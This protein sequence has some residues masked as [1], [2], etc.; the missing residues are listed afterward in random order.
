LISNNVPIEFIK[1]HHQPD[2]TFPHSFPNPL[3]PENR[4]D[5][6][7]AVIANQANMGIAGDEDF[8][9]CFLLMKKVSSSKVITTLVYWQKPF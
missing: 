7:S 4:A 2:G 3:L 1:V 9:R 5:T 8:E 6:A